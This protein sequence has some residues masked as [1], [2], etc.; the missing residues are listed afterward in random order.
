MP[1]KPTTRYVTRSE[2]AMLRRHVAKLGARLDAHMEALEATT[3]VVQGNFR[4]C[5]EV[6]AALDRLVRK[7]NLS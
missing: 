6:Q 7:L 5:A 2:F 3:I 4:R 1:K